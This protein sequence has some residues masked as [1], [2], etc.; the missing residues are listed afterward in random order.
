MSQKTTTCPCCGQPV[1]PAGLMLPRVKTRIFD[2]IRRRPG[3]SAETLA[4]LV[5]AED[6]N[7]GRDRKTIYVHISQLNHR[8]LAKHGVQIRG[9]CSAG[10]HVQESAP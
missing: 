3:I 8:W 2:L 4:A 6:P 10:Y 7:G 5:W 1:I 9:S